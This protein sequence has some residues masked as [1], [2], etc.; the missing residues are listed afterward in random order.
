VTFSASGLPDRT[1]DFGDDAPD[2]DELDMLNN[3]DPDAT[4]PPRPPDRP[5]L[6]LGVPKE[7]A[8][9]KEKFDSAML[10]R[11]EELKKSGRVIVKSSDFME[12]I[13]ESGWVRTNVYNR[14]AKWVKEDLLVE[15]D[16]GWIVVRG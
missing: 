13:A 1:I 5:P 7:D 2:A 15:G 10:A 12:I 4:I 14:L 3:V 11:L 6:R 16:E 8:W 9:P